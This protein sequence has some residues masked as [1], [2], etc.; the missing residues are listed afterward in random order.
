ML[1]KKVI[2]AIGCSHMYGMEHTSTDNNTKP[3]DE[4]WA[5]LLAKQHGIPVFNFSLCGA[6]NQTIFRRLLLALKFVRDN[7]FDPFFILQWTS[8]ERSEF[9]SMDAKFVTRDWPHIRFLDELTLNS[10]NTQTKLLAEHYYKAIDD[11]GLLTDSLNVIEHANLLLDKYNFQRLNCNGN[12]WDFSSIYNHDIYVYDQS[13]YTPGEYHK[14]LEQ[15]L[16]EYSYTINLDMKQKYNI[17]SYSK[18]ENLLH[19]S[20]ETLILYKSI[21]DYPWHHWN[22]IE[23]R[24]LKKF[25]VVNNY[26]LGPH[27]HPLELANLKAFEEFQNSM[28]YNQFLNFLE[29]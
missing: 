12:E 28:S 4:V 21:M 14:T 16:N 8:F 1:C 11:L 2:I 29:K 20:A 15:F 27:L 24:G 6:S 7:N 26:P 18:T 10:N 3:S 23:F 13:Q 5:S 25:A 17:T 19:G 22:N 9:A